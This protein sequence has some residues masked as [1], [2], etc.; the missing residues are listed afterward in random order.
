VTPRRLQQ[1]V[2]TPGQ[3]Y[4]WENHRVSDFG[5]TASGTVT[6]DQNGLVT[7]ANMEI[8]GDGNRLI[9]VP[10]QAG[11]G[12]GGAAEGGGPHGPNSVASLV[13]PQR[14]DGRF[15]GP[16][17]FPR[18]SDLAL[19]TEG[20][21]L[22]RSVSGEGQRAMEARLRGSEKRENLPWSAAIPGMSLK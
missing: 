14:L 21:A 13:G 16:G 20:G 5:L 4:R 19:V 10:N 3:A 17:D 7:I 2:V 12:A 1:F 18:G 15:D 8:T 11:G 6:A 22:Y 9:L